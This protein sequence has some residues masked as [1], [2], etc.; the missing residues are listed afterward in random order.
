MEQTKVFCLQQLLFLFE[1]L[2]MYELYLNSRIF[3]TDQ[4]INF[5]FNR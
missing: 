2:V 5:N 3:E 4:L 1:C